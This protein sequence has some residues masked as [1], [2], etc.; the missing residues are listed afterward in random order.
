MKTN[1][2][3]SSICHSYDDRVRK[4]FRCHSYK[5]QGWGAAPPPI[6]LI[7]MQKSDTFY[8]CR[9]AAISLSRRRAA[10][11]RTLSAKSNA[12]TLSARS[13]HTS[14]PPH[15]IFDIRG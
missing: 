12:R 6:Y 2:F 15:M 13:F 11:E 4:S 9:G 1:T 3:K 8:E 14:G 5:K 10:A 7:G